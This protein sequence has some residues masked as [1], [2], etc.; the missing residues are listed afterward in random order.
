MN[1]D[2][3]FFARQKKDEELSHSAVL[4]ITASAGV[5]VL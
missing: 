4:T 5:L 2:Y 3:H 1:F